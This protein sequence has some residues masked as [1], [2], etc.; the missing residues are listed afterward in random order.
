MAMA[1]DGP[2]PSVMFLDTYL[3]WQ[4]ACMS[5]REGFGLSLLTAASRN[6]L[7]THVSVW[8]LLEKLWVQGMG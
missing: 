4:Y 2:K 1:F 3:W 6:R 8:W 5:V 7:Y